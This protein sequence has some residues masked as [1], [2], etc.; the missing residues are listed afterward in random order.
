MADTEEKVV[1]VVPAEPV[2]APAKKATPPKEDEAWIGERLE[3]ERNKLLKDLGVTDMDAAK[4]A[5][6]SANESAESK[7]SSEQKAV[8]LTGKLAQIDAEKN[9]L[10]AITTEHAARMIGV[11]TAEQQA[12]VRNV[13]GEDPALQLKA[14]HAL[15]PTWAK[16][17][18]TSSAP[19]PTAPAAIVP[20]A[21]ANV[22]TEYATMKQS[23]P[24][25]A[26][27]YGLKNEVEVYK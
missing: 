3:R 27:A 13:A 15:A 1:P 25:A 11:L 19:A 26:A 23:N 7:K 9:R 5:I 17:A 8:E 10:L 2:T 20:G 12:A 4:A 24:F 14:V 22:K 16:E 21:P 18:P 6:K